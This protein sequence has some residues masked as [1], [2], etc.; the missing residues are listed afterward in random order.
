MLMNS[1]KLSIIQIHPILYLFLFVAIITGL[2]LEFMIVFGIVLIHELGHFGCARLFRWRIRRIF[3]W[4][5]GGV[6]ETDEY[7]SKPMYQEWLV[8]IAGPL[9]H[10]WI[11]VVIFVLNSYELLP[12]ATI[13]LVLQYNTFILLWNLLPIWP[14]DGGKLLHLTLES[15]CTFAVA[16][17]TTLIISV[18]TIITGGFWISQQYTFSLTFLLLILFLLWENRL[19]WKRSYY[20]WWQML[21]QRYSNP[22][23]HRRTKLMEV[24]VDMTLLQVFQLFKRNASYTIKIEGRTGD[25][26]YVTERECLSYFFDEQYIH[27]KIGTIPTD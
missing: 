3:L 23:T 5:F 12:A 13:E 11:Y 2:L 16:H 9:Q 24:P 1:R 17:K 20:R 7:G 6:M 26:H 8:T 22:I 4:V 19:E 18:I 27:A 21:W 25:S 14:L 10:L 15:F